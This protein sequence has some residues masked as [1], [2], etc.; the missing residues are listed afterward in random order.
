MI[1]LFA[2]TFHTISQIILT[3]RTLLL[4]LSHQYRGGCFAKTNFLIEN[5]RKKLFAEL[6]REKL[7]LQGAGKPV[8]DLRFMDDH[9]SKSG[10]PVLCPAKVSCSQGSSLGLGR[11]VLCNLTNLATTLS[12]P[13]R[14]SGSL[15]IWLTWLAGENLSTDDLPPVLQCLL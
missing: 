3:V 9:C 11:F 4:L 5:V 15:E 14:S 13:R 1:S 12:R 7:D 6:L 8:W 10:L 2:Y